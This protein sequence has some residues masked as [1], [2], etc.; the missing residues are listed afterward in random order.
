KPAAEERQV[1]LT[2][3]V[4]RQSSRYRLLYLLPIVLLLAAALVRT[5]WL[6]VIAGGAHRRAGQDRAA[7]AG[8]PMG[9]PSTLVGRRS[10]RDLVPPYGEPFDQPPG[11][12]QGF[13][14]KNEGRREP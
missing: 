8:P 2:V 14:L 3:V 11:I 10:L 6:C 9:S 1:D 7:S 12:T 13:T 4:D 5:K